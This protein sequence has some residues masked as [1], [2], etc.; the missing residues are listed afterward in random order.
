MQDLHNIYDSHAHYDD[1]RYDEDRDTL[2]PALHQQGIALINNI[3]AD[4]P[5]SYR[6]VELAQQYPFVYAVVGVHPHEAEHVP[7]DYLDQLRALAQNEKVVA[8]GEIGLDYHYDLSPRDVQKR[9]FR[10]Q[11]KLA[12]ELNLPVV[13]HEREACADCMEILREF[14]PRG[15]VH[16]FSGSAETAK[17]LVAMGM[18][19][20]FTGVI[21]FKN[22]RRA[23]EACAVVPDDRLLIETDCPYLAP[24]PH[25]GTRNDSGN[26]RYIAQT[27][28]QLRG[29]TAQQ[30]CDLTNQNAR[31]LFG[32]A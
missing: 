20:G 2:L 14:H 31:T 3:G 8:I 22:A 1:E 21:T 9:V 32:I 6:A 25:R 13:I 4:M 5:S 16:C 19:V 18:Y 23:L 11:L 17:E 10:E 26:L 30:V 12:Q 27:I 28:A 24:E 7:T 15:V 29:L